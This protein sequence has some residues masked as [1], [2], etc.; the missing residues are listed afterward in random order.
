MEIYTDGG[1]HGNPGPGA[2]AFIIVENNEKTA[3]QCGF[4]AATTNNR[5]ELMAVIG[6][7]EVIKTIR[8]NADFSV[9]TD[10][11]YVLKGITQWIH[12]WNAKGW[13][14]SN[15][16]PV[17]N[18]DLW[19]KLDVLTAETKPKWVWVKG[20][21]GNSWNELCDSMVKKAIAGMNN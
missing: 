20:H 12:S 5:M 13:V 7:L 6:A 19:Q 9:F 17:K 8:K 10:S 3:E 2:W 11:Q 4:E 16:K 18:Q 14:T 21:A 15:K 1:C